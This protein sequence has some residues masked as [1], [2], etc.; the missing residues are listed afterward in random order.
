MKRIPLLF[1]VA[2]LFSGCVDDAAPRG[3]GT[4]TPAPDAGVNVTDGSAGSDQDAGCQSTSEVCDGI[5]NDCDNTTDEGFPLGEVCQKLMGGCTTTGVW[6]CG[7]DGTAQ[8]DAPPPTPVEE[9]CDSIDNDCDESVD[10]TFMFNI[11]VN[12]CGGCNQV[13]EIPNAAVE[14]NAGLCV[15]SNC[16]DGF[17]DP[18]GDSADGCE[19]VISG[20]ETCNNVDDDC[21]G[22]VDEGLGLG[23]ACTAGLGPCAADGVTVCGDAG[24]VVCGATPA[25]PSEEVCN[26]FDE[27]CDGLV[28]ETFDVDGDGAKRCP[29]VDCDGP[30]PDGVNCE[31][32]CSNY[33]CNDEDEDRYP[34]AI[35]IC[36]DGVDQNCDGEDSPC[37]ALAGR[38]DT[39]ALAAAN[40]AGCRDMDGDGQVDNAFGSPLLLAAANGELATA[41]RTGQLNLLPVTQGL[42]AGAQEGRFEM[43]II[44]GARN[45]NDYRVD[46]SSLDADGNPV[47]LFG[48]ANL[49]NGEFAAGPGDFLLDLPINGVNVQILMQDAMITGGMVVG[50]NGL[51]IADAHVSGIISP[52]ALA[53][54]L[55]LV[56]RE[57]REL[58]GFVLMPDL[59]LDNDGEAE[60]Y[61]ACVAMSA[62]PATLIG[63]PVE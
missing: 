19:C 23:A 60:S 36:E 27:D 57:F 51:T 55:N 40:A 37:V 50:A 59:D 32:V 16:L 42:R 13:C 45:G 7:A 3:D 34:R 39:L 6:A 43:V 48:G 2:L 49:A 58:V 35:D 26:G 41:V 63:F 46:P 28:D 61:S 38:V 5:D 14:C 30:C 21:D 47:M 15:L 10:E 33:D 8:C 22:Q 9:I 1:S 53:D 62:V 54:G 18:N 12:H 4:P 56:P 20:P 17:G 11:D 31:V 44:V 52:E 24:D 25:P 29:D